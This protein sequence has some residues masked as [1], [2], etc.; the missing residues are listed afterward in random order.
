MG[1]EDANFG[2]KLSFILI[3]IF[4]SINI[5]LSII[6]LT[7]KGGYGYNGIL[8]MLD[9]NPK[10]LDINK[11]KCDLYISDIKSKIKFAKTKTMLILIYNA[12]YIIY[13]IMRLKGIEKGCK[14]GILF[15][16]II[17]LG[18]VCEL[19]FSSVS[20]NFYNKTKYDSSIFK[21]CNRLDDAFWISEDIFDG[22]KKMTKWVIEMDRAVISFICISFLPMLVHICLILIHLDN[23]ADNCINEELSCF[24]T[25]FKDFFCECLCKCWSS[26]CDIIGNCCEKFGKCCASCC[27]NDY[28]SL[29]EENNK[30]KRRIRELE[31]ETS[32]LKR[33]KNDGENRLT[34]ERKQ[35]E[36]EILII[37][38]KNNKN[39]E[40]EK[41]LRE[42]IT[43]LRKEIIDYQNE[44]IK[45]KKDNSNLTKELKKLDPKNLILIDNNENS[46]KLNLLKENKK[47]NEEKKNLEKKLL[48]KNIEVKQFE[49]IEFYLKN[50]IDKKFKDNNISL[51]NML[52]EEIKN[53]YE[54]YIDSD[55]FT[56]ISLFY[57][58]SKLTEHLTDKKKMKIFSY[59]MI[60]KYGVTIDRENMNQRDDDIIENKL[61]FKIC[62]ILSKNKDFLEMEDFKII[63]QLLKDEIRNDYYINPV[64]I[65]EGDKIGDTM[66]GNDNDYTNYNN[67][68]I[69][70]IITDTRELLEDDFFK[71]EGIDSDSIKKFVDYNNIMVVN[72]ISGDGIIN[73]GIKYLKSETFAEVEEKLYKIY[74]E[75]R[76][77]NNTF[78]FGGTSILR[79]KTI[80]Q[81]KIK[82]GDKIELIT[83]D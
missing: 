69:K 40:E 4:L 24:C 74:D 38:N 51:K 78:L 8:S 46:E 12:F 61:V 53:K 18:F 5:I 59:P 57:F 50:E 36:N 64:V 67:T 29:K 13:G 58:K 63:K 20:L 83:F 81:N 22:A 77:T 9:D 11:K 49:V 6:Q 23:Q 15:F 76:E 71:F 75:F 56:K 45:L 28:E 70:N 82:D 62:Q 2:I 16:I 73:Q 26:C 43:N 79:F 10:L 3:S 32:I 52:L 17:I 44:N 25:C 31:G 7:N 66:E 34:T 60:T 55:K 35:L 33:E 65:S 39:I 47:I 37:R 30:L 42:Q 68:V 14:I 54:L 1:S 41:L 48:L 21:N 72:F 27:G 80:E 19:V